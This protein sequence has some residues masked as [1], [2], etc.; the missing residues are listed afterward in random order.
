MNRSLARSLVL[1][2]LAISALGAPATARAADPPS[3]EMREAEERFKEGL[4]LHDRGKDEEARAKFLQAWAVL[5][6]P[7][8]LF[9]LARSEQL[10]HHDVDAYVHYRAYL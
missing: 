4:G 2:A 8:V 9:N 3:V 7:N 10:S 6:N 1:S 5:K